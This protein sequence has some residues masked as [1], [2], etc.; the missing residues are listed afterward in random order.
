MYREVCELDMQSQLS[1]STVEINEVNIGE[2]HV[3]AI[4]K[5]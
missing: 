5:E 3:L 4:A 1:L 2:L